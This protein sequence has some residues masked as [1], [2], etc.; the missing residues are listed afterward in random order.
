MDRVTHRRTRVVNVSNLPPLSLQLMEG[1]K[2]YMRGAFHSFLGPLVTWA[3]FTM[4][5]VPDRPWRDPCIC[6]PADTLTL[7][8]VNRFEAYHRKL[9]I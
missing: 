6:A 3:S 4:N 9:E 7:P 2:L 8:V 5:P 1:R